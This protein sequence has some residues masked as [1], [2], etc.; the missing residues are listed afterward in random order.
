[1]TEIPTWLLIL[2]LETL[3]LLALILGIWVVLS[4][5]RRRRTRRAVNALVEQIRQQ[6]RLRLEETGSFL[7]KKYRFEGDE[8]SK[9]VEQV[10]KAEKLFLQ[11]LL[12]LYLKRDDERLQSLDAWVAELI[13]VYK[14]LSP[15]MPAAG[16]ADENTQKILQEMERSRQALEDELK[17]TK[18]TMSNMI[19]EFGNMF[20]GGKDNE[21]EQSE[22]V[23]KVVDPDQVDAEKLTE[24]LDRE[25]TDEMALAAME[26]PAGQAEAFSDDASPS[27]AATTAEEMI[28]DDEVLPAPSFEDEPVSGG[29]D[30]PGE[31]EHPAIEM[32]DEIDDLLD[33]IDLSDGEELEPPK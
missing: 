6:S 28:E 11:R 13:G 15:V 14:S 20:G 8:L 12:N 4:I 16:E 18:T 21:L 22:V 9:A 5:R 33:G 25:P 32:D 7:E 30:L 24:I 10:D 2:L 3:G 17:V 1:M 29:E 23:E 19:A 26:T 31:T 27:A